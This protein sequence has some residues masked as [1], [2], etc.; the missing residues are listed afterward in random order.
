MTKSSVSELA[1]RIDELVAVGPAVL[2][3]TPTNV[4]LS[5][6]TASHAKDFAAATQALGWAITLEDSSDAECTIAQIGED[7]QPYRLRITKPAPETGIR[8]LTNGGFQAWLKEASAVGKVEVCRLSAS[9]ATFGYV[10][11]PWESTVK[12][13]TGPP[14]KSPRTLVR[15]AAPIRVAP[16]DIRPWLL[17]DAS[18]AAWDDPVF[19][20]WAQQAATMLS[21]ALATE[22]EPDDC[23]LVFAGPPKIKLDPPAVD[24]AQTLG[25]TGFAA[26][27]TAA[28][29]VYENERETETRHRLFAIEVAR[30]AT[31]RTNVGAVLAACGA[32]ALE[33]A[34]LAFQ[35]GLEDL[36]RD[37]L[38][39]LADLR[40]GLG[41]DAA[42]LAD[43][44][45]QIAAA[46]AGA[47]VLGL[48]LV[49]A[50]LGTTA[51]KPLIV[52]LAFVLTGYVAAVIASNL[53][54]VLLQRSIRKEWRGRL[55]RFLTSE[56]YQRMVSKPAHDAELSTF[57][58][59]GIGALLALI[60]LGAV[61]FLP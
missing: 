7:L 33:G 57:I 9:Y 56:D 32:Q 42:K 34:R 29:W 18:D 31:A 28:R 30:S 59:M 23:A 36:S 48:G 5:G 16:E 3:E 11:A 10:A 2:V 43:S 19:A 38:K 25:K 40:K 44:T 24:L 20:L 46:V 37:T 41:D 50:K 49:A 21:R 1:L 22:I 51:P 13:A 55:Y 52:V 12:A 35:L 53:Q 54:F 6:L 26:L 58:A 15:E 4:I 61:V 45:R 60:M 27:Q 17:A 39:A 14:L 47:L 8:Y